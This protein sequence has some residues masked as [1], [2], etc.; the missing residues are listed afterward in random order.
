MKRLRL[1][2]ARG[3]EAS[4][5]VSGG[6]RL[7]ARYVAISQLIPEEQ[8]ALAKHKRDAARGRMHQ[9]SPPTQQPQAS[10]SAPVYQRQRQTAKQEPPSHIASPSSF[11]TGGNPA[12]V[13]DVPHSMTLNGKPVVTQAGFRDTTNNNEPIHQHDAPSYT[14]GTTT[15]QHSDVMDFTFELMTCSDR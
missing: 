2:L 11:A 7:L 13:Q 5:F 4:E 1:V 8:L 15:G 3:I 6:P 14:F 10:S 12:T 9:Q